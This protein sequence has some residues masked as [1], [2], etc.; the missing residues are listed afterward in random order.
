MKKRILLTL[1]VMAL[2]VSVAV[3]TTQAAAENITQPCPHCG[4][5]NATFQPWGGTVA[6]GHY[7]LSENYNTKQ[8]KPGSGVDL[9]LDLRGNTLSHASN[10]SL[11]VNGGTV[12]I[13]DTD[14]DGD[15]ATT[16]TIS[17]G[18]TVWG[19][20]VYVGSG[21][22]NI[23]GGKIQGSKT[24]TNGGSLYMNNGAVVMYGGTILGGTSTNG[25][26]VYVNAGNF[27]LK[28]G[29]TIQGGT[30]SDAGGT[31]YVK[32]GTFQMDGAP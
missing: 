7:Y 14:V 6:S 1:L 21:R 16:G 12:T 15:P 4:G 25:G 19:G 26:T 28:D 17:G 30:A 29:A 20:A 5:N 31:M 2:L 18:N 27:T 11:F 9:V 24:T 22:L 23:Y 10:R 8:I 3:F 32:G 13:L